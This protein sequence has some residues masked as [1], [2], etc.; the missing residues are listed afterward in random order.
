M[1]SMPVGRAAGTIRSGAIP[2]RACGRR[3]ARNCR[4]S[5]ILVSAGMA[6]TGVGSGDQSRHPFRG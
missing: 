6:V 2:S 3:S 5:M 4:S 1:D